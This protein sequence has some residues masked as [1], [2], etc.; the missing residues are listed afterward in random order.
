[1]ND[2]SAGGYEHEIGFVYRFGIWLDS[3]SPH[4]YLG[5]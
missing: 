3:W 2:M 5:T 1:M 4:I